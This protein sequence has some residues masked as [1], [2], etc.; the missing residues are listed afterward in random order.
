M[1]YE[2]S[3]LLSGKIAE[4]IIHD[5]P[6]L[7]YS[8]REVERTKN[9]LT[10]AELSSLK[11]K[12]YLSFDFETFYVLNEFLRALR[13]TDKADEEYLRR[14]FALGKKFTPADFSKD[15]F[16]KRVKIQEKRIGKFLLTNATYS[17]GEF[18][19][20][21]M[22]DLGAPL[23]VSK[24]GFCTGEVSFPAIYEGDMPWMSACPSEI[25]SMQSQMK[26]AR[27]KV[28]VLGLGIGYYP[29]VVSEKDEV[30]SVTI[31]EIC[32]EIITLFRENILPYFAHPEKITIVE[33]DA[34]E[35]LK[36]VKEGDYDTCFADIWEG[37]EDGAA[38]YVKIKPFE[39]KLKKTKFSY[40][41]EEEIKWYLSRGKD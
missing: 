13:L 16:L 3:L 1:T 4:T 26:E 9:S 30:E 18:F 6:Y 41:I 35:F 10:P 19:Q 27:G 29:F 7:D 21:A 12:G 11:R 34:F 38:C 15:P 36:D 22:P 25:S 31:I 39:E 17:R 23:V 8:L 32:P 40:W 5:A 28:L 14:F 37:Q 20:Y 33:A 2:E 24:V